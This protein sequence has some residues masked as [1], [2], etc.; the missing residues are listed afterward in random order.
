MKRGRGSSEI[1]AARQQAE[2]EKARRRLKKA[3]DQ[4][5][6]V[7]GDF[8]VAWE[9]EDNVIAGHVDALDQHANAVFQSLMR[10][11]P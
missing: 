5:M 11:E 3:I 4:L 2:R 9:N 1:Y 6:N 10:L 8:S 7:T